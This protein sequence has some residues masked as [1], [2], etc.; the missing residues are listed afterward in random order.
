MGLQV[1]ALLFLIGAIVLGFTKKMNVG[2]VCLGLALILGKLGGMG[3]GDIYKGFPYKLFATLLGTMLFFSLLQQNG[4]LEKISKRLIGLCG[5][6][7]FLVPIIVYLVSFGLSAAGPGAISVQSVTVI[8]AVSLAIQMKVSPI[9]MGI[10]AILGAVGGT[11]SPIAL[12]G[13][14]VG[15]LLTEMGIEGI[16]NQI[17]IGVSI[18]NLICAIVMY[19]ILGGYKFRA[20][21]TGE[22]GKDKDP[23]NRSQLIS[24]VALLVMV[25]LV[26]GFS[27]D[28]GLICF[29][30]SLVLMLTGAANE[31]TA[32]KMIPWSVL[33][34]IA[35]VNVLMNITQKLGGIDL[36]ASILATFMSSRTAA[37][38]M[39]VTGG[40]M[41][42]F[43]SANGVVFP[44]LIPTVPEI[45]QQVGGASIVQ[46][47]TAIVCSATV[48]GISPLSTGGSLIMAS[49][50]QESGCDEKEQQKMFGTLFALSAGVVA[51]V[52]VLGIVGV[53]GLIG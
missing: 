8:F 9:L 42:W 30:L 15:D 5:K 35:G 29:T 4:T 34:L 6:N 47:V 19:I 52:F 32:L 2:V 16:V 40:I 39:G 12:T 18:S 13:I 50:A 37:P 22:S 33:I 46:M 3:A 43:S 24:L 49:Y 17:F 31:K 21:E 20:V 36:L 27:Y 25:V 44:T 28:V 41:S 45:A 26:V 51:I 53:L 1:I 38:I 23:F 7:T 48:A 10:M 11:A 14:I